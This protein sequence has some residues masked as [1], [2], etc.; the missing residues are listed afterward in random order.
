M[1]DIMRNTGATTAEKKE[2]T[3]PMVRIGAP[4]ATEQIKEAEVSKIKALK[5]SIESIQE[6]SIWCQYMRA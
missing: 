5:D 3:A 1:G 2:R 4:G 6:S